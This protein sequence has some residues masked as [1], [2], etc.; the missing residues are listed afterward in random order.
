MI[1]IY[2]TGKRFNNI[3]YFFKGE[4]TWLCGEEFKM[5]K[6]F[7]SEDKEHKVLLRRIM[8]GNVVLF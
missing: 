6:P 2:L 5:C 4:K 8:S 1:R 7:D 3:L